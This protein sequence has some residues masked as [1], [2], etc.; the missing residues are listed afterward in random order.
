MRD[1]VAVLR[2]MRDSCGWENYI[3]ALDYAIALAESQQDGA[4][5]GEAVAW[6]TP[7]SLKSLHTCRNDDSSGYVEAWVRSDKK[8][9]VPLYTRPAIAP[10]ATPAA[11]EA[12]IAEVR[13]S[14]CDAAI[15]GMDLPHLR[16]ALTAALAPQSA[17]VKP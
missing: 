16:A 10:Q 4:Q 9:T 5:G 17:E 2:E 12:L 1:H 7:M 13:Q 11:V 3:V 14:L 8:R 15:A 6:I